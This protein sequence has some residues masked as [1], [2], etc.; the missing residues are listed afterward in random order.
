MTT[1]P[2][3]SGWALATVQTA[4]GPLGCL[5]TPRG[6]FA[7]AASLERVGAPG[8]GTVREVLDDWDR[9]RPL[10]AEAA[11]R[12]DDADAVAD[13]R[14]LAPI[15]YPGK[16]VCAGANYFDH[17]EEMGIHGATKEN[18]RLFFFMK[19]PRNAVVG[20][21]DTV[22]MP[23]DTAMFDWE[24][25]LAVVIGRR[26]RAVTPAEA[27]DSI[28][29]YTVAMDL[30]A[31]DLNQAPDTFYKLDWNA[32][33]AQDTCCPLGPRLIPA[34]AIA[35]PGALGLR[36][37]V[38]G[39]TKQDGNTA[40]MIFPIAEQ[41]SIL[42]RIMTLDAGDVVLTGTPAGVGVPRGE[43]LQVGDRV[44]A[45]IDDIGAFSIRVQEPA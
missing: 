2:L 23:L 21:G 41:I 5:E 7:L 30:C 45:E 20:E 28:A 33:K 37:S 29:A 39:T 43:F 16:V 10:L 19:P 11:A 38:N 25:E 9:L 27:M 18:Q 13:E 31:R 17:L 40:S 8:Y 34:E 12:V 1:T 15:L 4:S 42:S 6:L 24:I 22:R 36:L 44:A 32:G 35:D 14:R 26:T 3:A